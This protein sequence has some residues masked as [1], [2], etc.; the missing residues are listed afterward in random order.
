MTTTRI[1][2]TDFNAL[3]SAPSAELTIVDLRSPAE[4][5]HENID[6]CIQI[7]FQC[8]STTAVNDKISVEQLDDKRVFLLCQSGMRADAAV[9]Q[10]GVLAPLKWVIIDGGLN[11]IKAAGGHVNKGAKTTISLERQVRIT[12]G[13]AILCGVI[14]GM[15]MHPNFFYIAAFVG[16]GLTFAGITNRCGLA[17][18]IARMPWNH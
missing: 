11:A 13:L 16:A 10:L 4:I 7:P 3:R 2:A 8:L 15:N 9:R 12:A 14:L 1:S 5:Q 17:F 6:H 18:L